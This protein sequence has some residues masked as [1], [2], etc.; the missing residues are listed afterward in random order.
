VSAHS[1]HL[2]D[3][4]LFE[5]YL[6]G[7]TGAQLDPRSAD[8]LSSCTE[9][10]ARYADL[11]VFMERLRD[12]A[13]AETEAEFP[14]ERL[15]V[16]HQ[17]I[18]RRIEQVNRLARVITF[19]GRELASDA[20]PGSR[21]T[22]RWVA[23]AAAAGLFIGVAVGGYLTP[24]RLYRSA[25]VQATAPPAMAVQRQTPSSAV[26]VSGTPSPDS[27]D[28]DTFL[29]ELE[30]ALARPHTLELQPFDA[31]TPHIQDVDNR[32]R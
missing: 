15:V 10:S 18:L 23:A 30:L 28:D 4:H 13:D 2:K 29:M 25:Q 5:C 7:C 26:L 20:H 3:D 17:Q 6:A 11:R 27:S 8:H 19:P 14:A 24:A 9:C 31:M 22:P 16:Q 12:D 1:A 21:L 32:T